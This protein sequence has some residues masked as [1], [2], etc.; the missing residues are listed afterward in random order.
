MNTKLYDVVAGYGEGKPVLVFCATRAGTVDTAKQVASDS[1]ARRSFLISDM[2]HRARLREVASRV[3]NTL[4]REL[5]E[6]GVGYHN[7]DLSSSDRAAVEGAAAALR[8]LQRLLT[9]GAR[10]ADGLRRGVL[11]AVCTT[12]TLAQGVN[13]PAH[14]V[15]IKST[16]GY[17]GA[18]YE[19]AHTCPSAPYPHTPAGAAGWGTKSTP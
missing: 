6:Q 10:P 14:L 17:R 11:T 15:I 16:L 18:G 13:L 1:Q 19:V 3:S 4:L 2:Q 9:G 5:I 12:S 8:K 7:S